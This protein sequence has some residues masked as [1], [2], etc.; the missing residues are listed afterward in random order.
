MIRF[1]SL[2][3]EHTRL[4]ENLIDKSEM[5]KHNYSSEYEHAVLFN[6]YKAQ[7]YCKEPYVVYCTYAWIQTDEIDSEEFPIAVL[8]YKPKYSRRTTF[9]F[10]EPIWK[11][12]QD[13][14]TNEQQKFI[15]QN[16]DKLNDLYLDFAKSQGYL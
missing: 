4:P 16:F 8:D 7:F 13:E 10:K 3:S 9:I 12:M 15:D 11:F 2:S 14:R 6:N 1:T 5:N